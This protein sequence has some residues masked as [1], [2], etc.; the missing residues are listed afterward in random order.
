MTEYDECPI[1]M[2]YI[3]TNK[4]IIITEC[5]HKFHCKC[6]MRNIEH[7]GFGC[8]YC[9]TEMADVHEEQLDEEDDEEDDEDDDETIDDYYN[10]Q[11]N[12]YALR[13]MRWLFAQANGDIIDDHDDDD[14]EEDENNIEDN[15]IILP[16]SGFVTQYLT[17]Q[18]FTFE[19]LI[20]CIL[21]KDRRYF[22]EP[23]YYNQYIRTSYAI[24]GKINAIIHRFINTQ[25]N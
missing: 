4:N 25:D 11:Q 10:E 19:D 7:N 14:D 15:D 17:Q 1:C 5:G 8:P 23:Y 3:E 2:E 21:I 16:S 18:G 12:Q 9:R 6:L 20:Q 13:G 24:G 22:N